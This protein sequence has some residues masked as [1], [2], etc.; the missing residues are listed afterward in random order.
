MVER[1]LAGT[2]AAVATQQDSLATQSTAAQRKVPLPDFA[3]SRLRADELVAQMTLDE[4]LSLVVSHFPILSPQAAALDMP[5][6]SGFTP[7]VPRLGIPAMRISDA[8]LGVAHILDMRGEDEATALPSSLATGASFD[9][10]LAFAGGAMIAGEARA[11]TFNVL[12]G[13]GINLTRDPWAGRN[14]EYL[15]EDALHSGVLGAAGVCGVQSRKIACTVKHYILNPQETGR[16]VVDGRIDEPALRE[17][18]LLAF[19]IAI[20]RSR[21]ASVMAAYNRVN[22][23][24]AS[25]N[26][27]LIDILKSDWGFAGWLMSD[28]GAT[29]STQAAAL[30]GL[31]QE[32]GFELDEKLN[33]EIYF[34][35][36]LRDAV[37]AGG[38]PVSRID[39]MVAR[40]LTGMMASGAFDAP[41]PDAPQAIDYAANAEVAQR[42]AEA[43]SVLLR[44]QGLLPLS[45]TLGRIAV[46]GGHADVG[47]PSG[48]GSSQ[49]RSVGGAPIERSLDSGDSSWFC[50]E[51]YHASSPVDAIRSLNPQS[52]VSFADGEDRDAAARAAA[53]A[54]VA[55]VF[56]NQWRTEAT[57][58]E[59]LAL[60]D[61]QDELI[62]AVAAANPRTIVVVQSGGAVLMP[63][64][65]QVPAVLAAWYPGQR[66]GEAVARILFGEVNPSG[67]LPL[68][69]PASDDSSPRPLPPGLDQ[70]RARDAAREAGDATAQIAPFEAVYDEGANVGYRWFEASGQVPLFPFGYGLSYTRFGYRD[71][72]VID[73]ATPRVRLIVTNDGERSGADVPQVYVRAVD[74]GGVATWRLAAFGRIELARG[75]AR[76]IELELEPR[77]FARWKGADGWTVEA[78][79]YPVAIGR[80]ATDRV[81]HGTLDGAQV[82]I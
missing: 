19:E 59:T 48:G 65:D 42:V 20:E 57:D 39:D 76:T 38:V 9:P 15:G 13:G 26:A 63:W 56:V 12:L 17:S 62:A 70:M 5:M 16:M 50:R 69:F 23:E 6:C 46:I 52:Q 81:L 3:A 58:L 72:Q 29:H 40:I 10:D 24:Y 51:T 64:L 34:T 74:A 41:V 1:S 60:P 80:S 36:K 21:P 27:T 82:R 61:G 67:R 11:K 53:Q 2:I 47:V 22:G 28:W 33:G 66:G 7:G 68:T 25:E 75:E 78:A 45:R 43:G 79:E 8:S 30:A 35:D 44:N 4:K 55:I 49:V 71:L 32:S 18:D 77:A 54:D 73:G 37:A 14:F 31:D